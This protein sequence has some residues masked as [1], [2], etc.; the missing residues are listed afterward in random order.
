M[1]G[2]RPYLHIEKKTVGHNISN[3]ALKI[4][5][6]VLSLEF[7]KSGELLPTRSSH[8]GRRLKEKKLKTDAPE[9]PNI[10]LLH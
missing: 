9:S 3:R 4:R 8:K 10:P 6:F 7:L 5:K 1:G 2:N